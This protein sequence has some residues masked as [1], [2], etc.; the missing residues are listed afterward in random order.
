M[1]LD[2][3]M[4]AGAFALYGAEQAHRIEEFRKSPDADALIQ[5][6]FEDYKGRYVRKFQDFAA[7]LASRG[8]AVRPA[9]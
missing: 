8:L 4:T 5:R 6:D 1:S 7:Q 9:A 3:L 2:E